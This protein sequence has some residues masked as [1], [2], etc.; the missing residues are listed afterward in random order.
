[1]PSWV[2]KQENQLYVLGGFFVSFVIVPML[3][4]SQVKGNDPADAL[5]EVHEDSQALMSAQLF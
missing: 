3:I 4:I 5:V 1:M 2:L